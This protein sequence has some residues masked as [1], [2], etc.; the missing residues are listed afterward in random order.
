MATLAITRYYA[1][2]MRG[3]NAYLANYDMQDWGLTYEDYLA[4]IKVQNKLL[5]KSVYYRA[6]SQ[7]FFNRQPTHSAYHNAYMSYSARHS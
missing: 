4:F 1:P 2:N 5:L 6:K 3:Y 7:Y